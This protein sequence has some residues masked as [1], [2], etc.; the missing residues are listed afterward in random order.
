VTPEPFPHRVLEHVLPS[1]TAAE[2]VRAFP[3]PDGAWINRAH[4]YSKKT[5]WNAFEAFPAIIQATIRYLYGPF[6]HQLG[7]ELGYDLHADWDL[8]G[9][10]LHL[11]TTGGFLGIH[12]DFLDHPTHPWRRVLNLLLYLN[13]EWQPGDGGEL[14]LWSSRDGKLDRCAAKIAPLHNR[15]VLFETS[16]TSFHGH[17][18][19][20]KGEKRRSLALY[21]Y[22]PADAPTGARTTDY[23]PR[24]NEYVKRLRKLVRKVIPR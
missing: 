11:T 4:L 3:E 19:P 14:E 13:P 10:G 23:R 18:D 12:A 22:V 2:V 21:Y 8:F 6:M 24:P 9:G 5:T 7:R 17:P 1:V 15:A 16:S 20:F